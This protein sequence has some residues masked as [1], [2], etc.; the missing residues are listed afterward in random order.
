MSDNDLELRQLVHTLQAQQQQQQ[1]LISQLQS[2][3]GQSISLATAATAKDTSVELNSAIKDCYPPHLQCS[4]LE[5]SERKILLKQYAKPEG[6]P[7]TLRDDN[8]LAA[9]AI[10]D[11]KDKKTFL[12]TIPQFQREALDILRVATAGWQHALNIQDPSARAN[13]LVRAIR[14][15]VVLSADNA[16]RMAEVQ[17]KG[18]FEAAGAK[19]GQAFVRCDLKN[20]DAD[21]DFDDNNIVQ[22]AHIEAMSDLRKFSSQIKPKTNNGKGKRNHNQ[23]GGSRW[24]G[25]G[26]WR[27]RGNGN[28]R[29]RG[30]GRGSGYHGGS[31]TSGSK[32][33]D[34]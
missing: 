1:Q 14:D 6:L 16:Q 17:I 5:A 2:G 15:V 31:S 4:P 24:R 34:P 9:K 8:G 20:A 28:W 27:G 22:A 26:G 32:N 13:F 29:G 3:V 21:I 30:R 33:D 25:G 19:G 23:G 7:K 10:G 12:N 18:I 11:G